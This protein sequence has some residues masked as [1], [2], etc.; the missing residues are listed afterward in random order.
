MAIALGLKVSKNAF[1]QA[2]GTITVKIDK[3]EDIRQSYKDLL[4][5][6]DSD[7]I[8]Q[9]DDNFVKVEEAVKKNIQQV[10]LAITLAT[11]RREAL[12]NA[13]REMEESGGESRNILSTMADQA[14]SSFES[15]K[16]HAQDI[17]G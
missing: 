4:D 17:L 14:D 13:V 12:T 11:K 1:L 3:L 5:H 7:V 6:L 10:Q 15:A 2:I 16:S 9:A 8:A